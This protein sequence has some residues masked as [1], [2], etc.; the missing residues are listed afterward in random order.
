[1]NTKI[2]KIE[3]KL[4]I[5]F[6]NN[7]LLM[8]STSIHDINPDEF[9]YNKIKKTEDIFTNLKKERQKERYLNIL[10]CCSIFSLLTSVNAFSFYVG[11]IVSEKGLI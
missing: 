9:N 10:K 4:K 1:M 7:I 2:Q 6:I 11:Y 3:N 5:I 8:R